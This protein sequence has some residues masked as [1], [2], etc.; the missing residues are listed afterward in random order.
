MKKIKKKLIEWLGG[1]TVEDHESWLKYRYLIGKSVAY[2]DIL[3]EMRSIGMSAD[4]LYV[5]IYAYIESMF[6]HYQDLCKDQ[7]N[8]V[9]K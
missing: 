8:K 1:V 6:R 5:Y 9:L 3:E 2:G 4:K 7:K